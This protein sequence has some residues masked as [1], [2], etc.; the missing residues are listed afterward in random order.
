[1]HG[2]TSLVHVSSFSEN[3]HPRQFVRRLHLTGILTSLNW[4]S[5][6]LEL[7]VCQMC[8]LNQH[9]YWYYSSTREAQWFLGKGIFVTQKSVPRKVREIKWTKIGNLLK[10]THTQ[11]GDCRPPLEGLLYR[12]DNKYHFKI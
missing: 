6:A 5:A 7:Y 12:S 1:M 11:S 3:M 4:R 10:D 2:C 8:A 9:W